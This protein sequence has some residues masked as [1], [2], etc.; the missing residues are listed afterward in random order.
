MREATKS[1]HYCLSSI[2]KNYGPY[3]DVSTP[4]YVWWNNSV[5]PEVTNQASELVSPTVP[6]D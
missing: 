2:K 5:G 3:D 1:H 4:S 6:A